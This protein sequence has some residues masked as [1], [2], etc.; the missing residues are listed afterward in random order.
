M[1]Q[2]WGVEGLGAW[3]SHSDH[4]AEVAK[5]AEVVREMTM[6]YNNI[7]TG[8]QRAARAAASALLEQYDK[9][10]ASGT[11]GKE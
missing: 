7:R 5:W 6:H 4:V 9:E 3:V 11:I 1:I 8:K 10:A 2:R